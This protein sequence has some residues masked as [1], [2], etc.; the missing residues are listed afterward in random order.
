MLQKLQHNEGDLGLSIPGMKERL[1]ELGGR[2][3]IHSESSGTEIE[4][5]LPAA[6]TALPSED[7]SRME[8]QLS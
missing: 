8:Q 4:A 5:F 1:R 2:M 7:R 3:E 6:E